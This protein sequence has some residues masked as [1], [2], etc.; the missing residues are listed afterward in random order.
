MKINL[1]N[2]YPFLLQ[3]SLFIMF[4]HPVQSQTA[5]QFIYKGNTAYNAGNFSE[6]QHLYQ[7]AMENDAAHQFPQI[8]FNLGNALFQQKKYREAIQQFRQLADA[9]VETSL[10]AASSY[11][12]GNS[13]FE[14]KNYAAALAAYKNTL[15]L[16]P[17]DEDA[18]YNLTLV[19]ALLA[20]KQ[21]SDKSAAQK[22]KEIFQPPPAQ[23]LTPEEQRRLLD[24]LNAAENKTM[25]QLPKKL[26]QKKKNTKDW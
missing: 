19:N 18:R 20:T 2:C 24:E 11:N 15:R 22:P 7:Q 14:Q 1:K 8:Q 16:N 26:Q 21:V 23:Q 6:A 4:S 5:E 12:A 10:K 17:R 25:Q 13:Y 3:L 9:N